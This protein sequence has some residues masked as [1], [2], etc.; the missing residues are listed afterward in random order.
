MLQLISAV[1]VD[2]HKLSLS[3]VNL[4]KD[5]ELERRPRLGAGIK[6]RMMLQLN[7]LRSGEA[8]G[9]GK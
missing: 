6:E 2:H 9:R 1:L 3:N 8:G 7:E 5:T 4:T